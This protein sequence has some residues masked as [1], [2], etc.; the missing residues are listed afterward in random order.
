LILQVERPVE[1][2]AFLAENLSISKSK[3]KELIDS[4]QVFVNNK[5][6]WIA[7]YQLKT[8]DTVNINVP[9]NKPAAAKLQVIYEDYNIIAVNKPPDIVSDRAGDSLE[10]LLRKQTNNPKLCAIHRLDKET[11]G[12]ILYAKAFKVLEAFK[13]LWP[14]KGVEKV[15][16]AVS[17]GEAGFKNR[18]I[19]EPV[20][21]KT[22]ISHVELISKGY[23]L[24]VFRIKMETGRKHQ[25]RIHLKSIGYPVLGDKTYG[26][27][28]I[29]GEWRKKIKRQMLHA[30]EI[31][32]PDPFSGA[33]IKITAPF[34]R[35]F[36]ET[37]LKAGFK[38]L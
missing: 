29:E 22:A 26:P 4:K 15:Y 9:E 37:A 32:Y 25:I 33:K 28:I 35:D 30:R 18:T 6:V 1:L 3:A 34:P 14:D 21:G 5:R 11:S 19:N 31:M 16:Y 2:K 8:G 24:S 7:K 27:N 36:L 17:T 13:A 10:S 20:E 23:G 12:V 38:P